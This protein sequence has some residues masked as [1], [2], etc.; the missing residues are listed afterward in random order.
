MPFLAGFPRILRNIKENERNFH[1]IY[2]MLEAEGLAR[3]G[4]RR[5]IFD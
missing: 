3:Y 1:L 4:G 2:D 5:T